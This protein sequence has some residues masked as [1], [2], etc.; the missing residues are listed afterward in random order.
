MAKAKKQVH[1]VE[2][3]AVLSPEEVAALKPEDVQVVDGVAEAVEPET[4]TIYGVRDATVDNHGTHWF[5]SREARDAALRY[6][7]DRAAARG[8]KPDVVDAGVVAVERALDPVV[9]SWILG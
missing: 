1:Q 2:P 4:V 9:A 5:G 3:A 8:S 7:K 6:A